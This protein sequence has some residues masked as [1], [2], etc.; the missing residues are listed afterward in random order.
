M[1]QYQR[2]AQA[3]HHQFVQVCIIHTHTLTH[4][5]TTSSCRRAVPW[6]LQRRPP[7]AK[8]LAADA[9][10]PT[11]TRG[12]SCLPQTQQ[13]PALQQH[14]RR[15]NRHRPRT[16]P[17]ATRRAMPRTRLPSRAPTHQRRRKRRPGSGPSW[18]RLTQR[19][20]QQQQHGHITI[21]PGACILLHPPW[22]PCLE[23]REPLRTGT[24]CPL[25]PSP[26]LP[27]LRRP[28]PL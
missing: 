13:P 24:S 1:F 17:W 18:L 22:M 2:M 25:A 15:A 6:L 11:N 26:F 16:T 23:G 19:L 21:A 9:L 5:L 28:G 14:N 27:R 8:L 20:Q 12:P 10:L 7:H 3:Y 4:I